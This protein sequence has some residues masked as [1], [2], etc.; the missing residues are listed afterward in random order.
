MP[1]IKTREHAAKVSRALISH[2]HSRSVHTG[3]S[4]SPTYRIWQLMKRRCANPARP[5]FR[6]YGG[7]GISVCERWLSFENF[8]ADMGERP[9]APNWYVGKR[10]YW[11]LTRI[12]KDGDY[13]PEN[14]RWAPR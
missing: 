11:S 2:G 6:Y 1:G 7:R 4:E 9:P 10:P 5:E 13:T 3:A 8:L 12:D 14:C